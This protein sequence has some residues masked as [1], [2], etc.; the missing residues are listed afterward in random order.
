MAMEENK[1]KRNASRSP[2][3]KLAHAT[4][5]KQR[6]LE[7]AYSTFKT[8]VNPNDSSHSSY[9]E[10]I[11]QFRDDIRQDFFILK[12]GPTNGTLYII[13]SCSGDAYEKVETIRKDLKRYDFPSSWLNQNEDPIVFNTSKARVM[14]KTT[15]AEL[16]KFRQDDQSI[17][18]S[19]LDIPRQ[20]IDDFFKKHIDN[21]NR[22]FYKIPRNVIPAFIELMDSVFD[23]IN[24]S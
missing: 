2:A 14:Q 13:G 23:N 3:P 17:Q 9:D 18:S 22:G 1:K 19:Y 15:E 5:A 4:V 11:E 20:G 21:S 12:V 7:A 10:I 16:T 6:K 8:M 24:F